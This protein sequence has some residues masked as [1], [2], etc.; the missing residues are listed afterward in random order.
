MVLV[1]VFWGCVGVRYYNSVSYLRKEVTGYWSSVV[2]GDWDRAYRYESPLF[3]KVVPK[4]VYESRRANPMAK[5]VGFNIIDIS[6]KDSKGCSVVKLKVD[7][8]LVVPGVRGSS[9]ISVPVKEKW[10]IVNGRWYH[11]SRLKGGKL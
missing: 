7:L 8:R 3:K 5:V 6:P 10:C 11:I 4:D 9:K 1:V 2:K